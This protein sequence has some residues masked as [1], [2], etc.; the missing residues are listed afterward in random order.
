MEQTN[1]NKMEQTKEEEII[2]SK[3]EITKLLENLDNHQKKATKNIS[4]IYTNLNTFIHGT[5][6]LRNNYELFLKKQT[7][8]GK[9]KL[10]D[11][12]KDFLK[13]LSK[14]LK[15]DKNWYKKFRNH[16]KDD[17]YFNIYD[18]KEILETPSDKRDWYSY[19]LDFNVD[20]VLEYTLGMLDSYGKNTLERQKLILTI[21][22]L[23]KKYKISETKNIY[24]Y[25]NP[26]LYKHL[27]IIIDKLNEKIDNKDI[28]NILEK[29]GLISEREYLLIKLHELAVHNL[30]DVYSQ[31]IRECENNYKKKMVRKRQLLDYRNEEQQKIFISRLAKT[32]KKYFYARRAKIETNLVNSNIALTFYRIITENGKIEIDDIYI[33]LYEQVFGF[34]KDE[35]EQYIN[36][37]SSF[38]IIHNKE[39]PLGFVS[40]EIKDSADCLFASIAANLDDPKI[41]KIIND[42]CET[43]N[44]NIKYLCDNVD[45]LKIRIES[46][47]IAQKKTDIAQQILREITANHLEE[48]LEK[49]K[50]ILSLLSS[51]SETNINYE[52]YNQIGLDKIADTY[53]IDK[54]SEIDF[55]NITENFRKLIKKS[56]Y[57]NPS[58]DLDEL[59]WGDIL[60]F[61]ILSDFFNK[62]F[63]ILIIYLSGSRDNMKEGSYIYSHYGQSIDNLKNTKYVILIRHNPKKAGRIGINYEALHIEKEKEKE[64]ET[65]RVFSVDKNSI[66]YKSYN[67]ELKEFLKD[68]LESKI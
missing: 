68:I 17:E 45:K 36:N 46:G 12:F 34:I 11:S 13:E 44:I 66:E 37:L 18:F 43:K 8:G 27:S 57:L 61:N 38:D 40:T 58:I 19:E 9:K 39:L 52:I 20:Q 1:Y 53:E 33:S 59:Y 2:S 48:Y 28:N 24:E 60:S 65:I 49:N 63:G 30:K 62:Y 10:D 54:L 31:R 47:Y 55:K 14:Y 42:V 32:I 67:S 50:Y 4:D 23:K 51:L 29:Y 7:G 5:K 22:H 56:E 6:T 35:Y 16:L 26:K 21:E 64:K 15:K 41:F 3:S 25:T